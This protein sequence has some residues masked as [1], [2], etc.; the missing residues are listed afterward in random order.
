LKS[1]FVLRLAPFA[2]VFACLLLTCGVS[3][4]A[5]PLASWNGG[6]SKT[7]ILEFVDRVTNP[8]SPDLVPAAQR[9]AVF[10]NDGTLW[11]EQPMY[12]QL[13]FALDRAKSLMTHHPKWK[14]REPFKAVMKNDLKVLAATGKHGLAELVMATHAGM[15]T[16][17][18]SVIASDWLDRAKHPR[19]HRPYTECVYSPML[20]LLAFLRANGFKTYV[21]SGGGVEMIRAFSER[22]YGVPPEQVIGSTIKTHFEVR[23]G[24]PVL[25]REAAVDF[26]DDKAGKPVAINTFIGRRPLMAFG[27]SDGDFE[28]L[29]WTTVGSGPRFGMLIHHTGAV[30]E[31]AYDHNTLFGR[32]SRGLDE[33]EK[34]GWI[35]VDMKRDWKSVFAFER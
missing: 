8:A 21:V 11:C 15:T 19:F 22:V 20:E 31:Y 12:V 7:A 30:R 32:L 16:D 13:A 33:A 35:V 27:N 3:R 2:A 29:E 1:R 17:E 23:N 25:V 6:R 5:E 4:A 14:E 26:I 24:K 34:R 10:D 18:F 28:M 9:I